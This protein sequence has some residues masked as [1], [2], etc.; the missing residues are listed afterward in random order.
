MRTSIPKPSFLDACIPLGLIAGERRWRNADG[1]RLYTW[2][3]LH[4]EIECVTA[5][6]GTSAQ[7]APL[8]E[9]W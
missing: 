5:A 2:D 1:T 4:G 9:C 6:A 3:S 7:S 8:R